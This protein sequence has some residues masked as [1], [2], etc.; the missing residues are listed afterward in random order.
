VT[1]HLTID[2]ETKSWANLLQVGAWAYSEDA[3]TDVVCLSYGIGN[4]PVRTWWPTMPNRKGSHPRDEMPGDLR[5]AVLSGM[6]VEAHNVAFEWSVWENVLVPKYGWVLPKLEQ[7]RDTMAVACYYALPAKLEQLARALGYPGKNPEGRRLI[8]KYSCLYNKTA[9]EE[10]PDD[11]FKLFVD[12]CVQDTLLEQAVSDELG[13]LPD[14]ELPIFQLDLKKGRRGLV[15]DRRGIAVATQ[16]VEIRE[17][18]LV[19]EFERLVGVKPTQLPK[20]KAWLKEQGIDLP[21]MRADTIEEALGDDG[22]IGQGPARRA[23]E[24]RLKV[25]TASTQ[26]LDAMARHTGPDGTAKVQTRYHGAAP[27]RSTGTGFQPLNLTRGVEE[28]KESR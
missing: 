15:L 9:K 7:W 4:E 14:R 16:V 5:R 22:H 25:N 10:I 27:G 17:A 11:D 6:P 19:K 24:L 26:K 23:L 21:D 8:T 18:E 13:D 2:F 12:Y 1:D 3:T 20:F 28:E